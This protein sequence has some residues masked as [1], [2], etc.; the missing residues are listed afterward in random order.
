MVRA[1]TVLFTLCLAVAV[2]GCKVTVSSE[3]FNAEEFVETYT[4][5]WNTHDAGEVAAL[6]SEDGDLAI[7]ALPRAEGR[8]AV[9]EWWR[10]YFEHLDAGREGAFDIHAVRALSPDVYLVNVDTLTSGEDASGAALPERRA[11]GAWVVVNDDGAWRI[12]AMWG[13]PAAGEQRFNPGVD[14]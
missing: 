1:R 12:A 7:G 13:L 4:A 3:A 10:V 5:A 6:F 8:D 9:E 14:N 2:S 11:R